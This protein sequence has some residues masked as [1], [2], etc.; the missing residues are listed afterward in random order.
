MLLED[1][2]VSAVPFNLRRDD[3]DGDS[4]GGDGDGRTAQ[5]CWKVY[6]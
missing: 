5:M 1:G 4:D 3:V 6:L 2:V